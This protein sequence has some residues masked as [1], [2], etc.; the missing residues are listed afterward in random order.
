M[1]PLFGPYVS[2]LCIKTRRHRACSP[3]EWKS[4]G[5]GRVQLQLSCVP[6]AHHALSSSLARH[7]DHADLNDLVSVT[8]RPTKKVFAFASAS[9]LISRR[10]SRMSSATLESHSPWHVHHRSHSISL[11]SPCILSLFLAIEASV[12]SIH[13]LL[14]GTSVPTL[15]NHPQSL[16][17]SYTYNNDT[18]GPE[19]S[20]AW[21]LTTPPTR[22]R[23][24]HPSLYRP[25]AL[26][27][28]LPTA[29]PFHS[30]S[31]H[32]HRRSST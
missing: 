19:T 2:L 22:L 4:R 15:Y 27:A 32:Y 12:A 18:S 9:L 14:P 24:L 8:D 26:L 11:D 28:R 23:L 6:N 1:T 25:S 5:L 10:I 20:T 21:L 3:T 7:T 31:P 30:T 13:L 29:C 17:L 16:E